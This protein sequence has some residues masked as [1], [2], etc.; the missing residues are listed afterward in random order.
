[1]L[2]LEDPRTVR[3]YRLGKLLG[4]EWVATPYAWVSF[5][6]FAGLGVGLGLLLRS[7]QP[8]GERLLAGLGYGLALCVT[9]VLHT[10]GH[11][12]SGMLVGAPMSVV[13]LTATFHVNLFEE[14]P[15]AYSGFVHLVRALGGPLANLGIG[16]V[17]L[18]LSR[19]AGGEGLP[20]AATANLAVAG[21][22][23]CPVPSLDG[24]TILTVLRG[25]HWRTPRG[26]LEEH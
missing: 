3:R 18:G 2:I 23:L 11:I 22:A 15:A 7:S 25:R 4:V 8:L 10:A 1:M 6:L 5:L 19:L 16:L 20:F 14:D 9:Q 12:L 13:L 17:A 26:G 21:W 24:W